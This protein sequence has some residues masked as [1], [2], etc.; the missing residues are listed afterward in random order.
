MLIKT[1]ALQISI[2]AGDIFC[3]CALMEV[4]TTLYSTAD[5]CS[6]TID[7]SVWREQL[8]RWASRFGLDSTSITKFD[9]GALSTLLSDTHQ[10]LMQS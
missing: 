5:C 8:L 7:I 2:L 4:D 6:H 10:Q 1:A 9:L 3:V